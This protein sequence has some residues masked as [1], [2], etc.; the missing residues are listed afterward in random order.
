[1]MD[2]VKD[3][4]KN[5]RTARAARRWT[6]NREQREQDALIEARLRVQLCLGTDRPKVLSGDRQTLVDAAAPMGLEEE[7]AVEQ[8]EGGEAE[9]PAAP[10]DSGP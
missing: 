9:D 6:R 3:A 5:W 7:E 1:M 4:W 8:E 10:A 2:R